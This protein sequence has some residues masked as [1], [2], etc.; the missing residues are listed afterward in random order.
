M[1]NIPANEVSSYII[2][3]QEE[4]MKRVALELHEGVGQTLYSIYTGLQ[5]IET[6]VPQPAMKKYVNDMAELLEKTIQEIRFFSVE[7]YPPTLTSL[8]LVAALKNYVKLYISTFG[9][10][11]DV[12]CHGK[13]VTLP[14][15][16][17]IILFRVCQEALANIAKYA[18]TSNAKIT[19][20]W[21]DQDVTIEIIDYGQGFS[22]QEKEDVSFGL[23]SMKERMKIV[24]GNCKIT[25]EIGKGTTVQIHLKFKVK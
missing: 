14:E 18:D 22:L 8:G 3:S 15:H 4:E 17:K 10:E 12:K 24:E 16:K 1:E 20:F 11:V 2:K 13:E 21:T 5:V 7:L 19:F 9:I 6:G 25:S 23:A